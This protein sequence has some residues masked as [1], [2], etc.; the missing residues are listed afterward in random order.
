MKKTDTVKKIATKRKKKTSL[1]AIICDVHGKELGDIDL[2]KEIFSVTASSKLLAQYVRVYLAN[3]RQG[4]QLTKTRSEVSGSTRKIY[5]Q[6]GTGRARH[7]DIKAPIFV[8]GG[9]A[10]GPKP[11]DFSLKINKKQKRKALFSALTQR[12]KSGDI[13][14]VDGLLK[15]KPK[16]K[17]FVKIL[18]D[19]KLDKTK[20]ILLVLP[21]EKSENLVLA[22]RNIK[23]VEFAN[24]ASL[25][26][27]QVLKARKIIF[28]K[29]ALPVLLNSINENRG[30]IN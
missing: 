17:N 11:R 2:P 25:N 22:S 23:E 24:V 29:E 30:N 21:K 3:Q 1:S 5:R 15:I 12:F 9:V 18:A 26:A 10:H 16:T 13:Y 7:G 20:S 28:T 4:T 8:G 27:Y 19:L 6:K 14:F